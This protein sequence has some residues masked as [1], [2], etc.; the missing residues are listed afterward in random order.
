MSSGDLG[1]NFV[2]DEPIGA[3]VD[4]VEGAIMRNDRLLAV[5]DKSHPYRRV[6][7]LAHL[8]RSVLSEVERFLQ[9]YNAQKGEEFIP[10]RRQDAQRAVAL[11]QKGSRAFASGA[12]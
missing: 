8:D 7:A 6:Q 12:A 10:L 2:A 11:V 1:T 4:G 3:V 9:F 5:A